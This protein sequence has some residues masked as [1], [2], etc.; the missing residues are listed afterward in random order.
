MALWL[1]LQLNS[2]PVPGVVMQHGLNFVSV[3]ETAIRLRISKATCH[4]WTKAG[5]LP[6]IKIGNR[7]LIPLS[8]LESLLDSLQMKGNQHE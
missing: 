3:K 6:S 5:I 8:D 4:R 2:I 1:H 7:R